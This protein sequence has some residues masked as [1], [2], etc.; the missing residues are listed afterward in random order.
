VAGT[1]DGSALR[2]YINGTM[3]ASA[4]RSGVLTTN[5][6]ALTIGNHPAWVRPF[7][8]DIDEVRIWSRA[9]TTAEIQAAM[10]VELSGPVDGLV[11]Y[12]QLNDGSGQT[13]TD[14]SG[15]ARNAVL[16]T[17][18]SVEIQDPLWMTD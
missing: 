13:V 6:T 3:V 8:G 9:R 1:Y 17:T 10:N 7:D 5:N 15:N 18:T 2:L 4:A 16:G 11:A 12:Y 14:S